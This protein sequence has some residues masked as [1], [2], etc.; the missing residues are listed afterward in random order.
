MSV[1]MT[2][3]VKGDP[4]K[5]EAQYVADKKR[6]ANV[7]DKG[8]TMGATYHRFYATDDEILVV[9]EWPDEATFQSFFSGT[10]EIPTIMA[11]A[12]VTQQPTITFWHELELGDSI[13]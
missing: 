11:E 5:L 3:R 9:D 7:A 10:P 4:K 8:K 6:F 12:G 2:L 13:G 1:L